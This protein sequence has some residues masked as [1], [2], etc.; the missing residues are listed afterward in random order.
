MPEY[1]LLYLNYRAIA[2]PIR[3]IFAYAEVPYEDQR[4]SFEEWPAI[5]PSKSYSLLDLFHCDIHGGN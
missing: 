4:I 1:K 3:F 2:E 5:K